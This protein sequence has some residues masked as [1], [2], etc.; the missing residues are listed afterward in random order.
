[1][2]T[3]GSITQFTS[4]NGASDENLSALTAEGN[5][6]VQGE[7][8]FHSA[9]NLNHAALL[10]GLKTSTGKTCVKI[11]QQDVFEMFHQSGSGATDRFVVAY[12]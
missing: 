11:L 4:I 10:I 6:D 5:E 1:M 9:N 3:A 7:C 2:K 8:F 12:L